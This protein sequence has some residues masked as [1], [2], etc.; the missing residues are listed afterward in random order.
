M[1]WKGSRATHSIEAHKGAVTSIFTRKCELGV[2]T[3]GND[4]AYIVWG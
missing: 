2:I 3:A 1:V 4:G